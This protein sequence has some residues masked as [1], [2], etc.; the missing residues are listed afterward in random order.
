MTKIVP[1][2]GR[3]VLFTPS[4]LTGDGRFAHI[5][6]RSRS[7][8]SSLTV[9]NN[10]LVNLAVFDSNGQPHSR[11]SVPLVQEGEDKPEHTVISAPG[12]PTRSGR[13]QNAIFCVIDQGRRPGSF[14]NLGMADE[15]RR[16]QS[17]E[18]KPPNV[19]EI[20]RMLEDYAN[21][22]RAIIDRLR[23]KLN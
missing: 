21:D 6:S 9:F 7:P 12:Y 8:R 16:Q 23:K 3:V 15:Q 10:S 14:I 20:R 11:T 2:V 22:L 5:D 13:R 4:R 18:V 17:K 1:T 19:E